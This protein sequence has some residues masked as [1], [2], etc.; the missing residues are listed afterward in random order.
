MPLSHIPTLPLSRETTLDLNSPTT[1]GLLALALFFL[2]RFT[3]VH[4]ML[5]PLPS[6]KYAGIS[7]VAAGVAISGAVSPPSIPPWIAGTAACV[8]LLSQI[9]LST[10][11]GP[12]PQ[13]ADHYRAQQPN[14]PGRTRTL[15]LLEF[16]A[17]ETGLQ[18]V[19]QCP[20]QLTPE[21][22]NHLDTRLRAYIACIISDAARRGGLGVTSGPPHGQRPSWLLTG[23]SMPVGLQQASFD[24]TKK[25]FSLR[26]GPIMLGPGSAMRA[27]V[28]CA[29]GKGFLSLCK[30]IRV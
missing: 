4:W 7:L 5:G 13:Q 28:V 3:R 8:I 17:Y 16:E 24:S 10:I 20:G 21:N 9:I 19:Y 15:Y 18:I 25:L 26:V 2:W 12:V 14:A 27:D 29:L 22:A 30:V 6:L 1:L 23:F 11:P